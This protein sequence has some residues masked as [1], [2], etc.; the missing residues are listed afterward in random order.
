MWG[1]SAR[2]RGALGALVMAAM[3]ALATSGVAGQMSCDEDWGDGDRERFCEVREQTLP[4]LGSIDLDAGQNGGISVEGW[5]RD[6]IRLRAKVWA[7][8]P[9]LAQAQTVVED[10]RIEVSG[11]RIE[12]DGP[13]QRRKENWGVSFELMVP[14]NT[15]LNLETMNGGI[16][17]SNVESRTRF[18]AVNGGVHLERMAGSVEGRTTNGGIR[19]A[20]DGREWDG[21]GLDVRTTNGG[22]SLTIPDGYSAQL[23]T[24]TVNGSIEVDFPVTVRGRIGREIRTTLGEG[25]ATVRAMTTNGGVKILES[26]GARVR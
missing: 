7:N 13:E 3:W 24:G 19:I 6:E 18:K 9:S 17:I 21:S 2:A 15:D 23:E 5:D 12:A 8:A 20:L 11:S 16:A 22:V 10:I 25:G 14:R 4:S 1:T 26:E